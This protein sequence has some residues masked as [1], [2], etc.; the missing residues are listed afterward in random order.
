[1]DVEEESN[2]ARA[3]IQA[4]DYIVSY[5]GIQPDTIEALRVAIKQAKDTGKKGIETVIYRDAKEIVKELEPGAM[6]VTLI[7]Q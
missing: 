3:D 6:G 2:A 4:G 1:L 5:N 7:E